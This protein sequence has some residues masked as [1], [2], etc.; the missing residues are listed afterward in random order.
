MKMSDEQIN[1]IVAILLDE[2]ENLS[3]GFQHYTPGGYKINYLKEIAKLIL[4]KLK[5]QQAEKP[6]IP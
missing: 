5:Q 4:T 3:D 2:E 6:G 1:L